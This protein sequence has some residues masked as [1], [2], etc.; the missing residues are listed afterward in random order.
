MWHWKE[1]GVCWWVGSVGRYIVSGNIRNDHPIMVW[2]YISLSLITG[3]GP[4]WCLVVGWWRRR[5]GEAR[6]ATWA[7]AQTQNSHGQKD[8]GG[9]AEVV[10]GDVRRNPDC[11][12]N[13]NT[14]KW[15][16]SSSSSDIWN[17]S[18]ADSWT[19]SHANSQTDSQT[20]F[21]LMLGWWNPFGHWSLVEFRWVCWFS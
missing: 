8:R 15:T 20:N 21:F 18:N 1:R 6:W 19:N 10:L 3:V 14:E 5:H 9:T 4:S 11:R 7:C 13:T 12:A 2:R 17:D 16:D